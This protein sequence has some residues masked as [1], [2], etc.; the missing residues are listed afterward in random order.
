[1]KRR[2]Y[3]IFTREP[4]PGFTK[5]R[6]MPYLSP[7]ECVQLHK[8]F[9]MDY[10]EMI[11]SVDADVF[12]YCLSD[13]GRFEFVEGCFGDAAEV[14][15]QTGDSLNRKMD[16]A[17]RDVLAM[18]YESCVLTGCDIP[19]LSAE[20][21]NS[22]F[23]R[24][25]ECDAVIGPT[26][27]GGYYLIG[28]N[29]HCE[30]AFDDGLP[31]EGTVFENTLSALSSTGMRTELADMM[32]DLDTPDDIRMYRERLR[33]NGRARRSHT[34]ECVSEL[35]RISIIVPVYN[36][37]TTVEAMMRQ[38]EP[39]RDK[40]EIVFV[41][42]GSSDRTLELI[43]NRYRVI[44]SPKGRGIQMNAGAKASEGDV[45]FFLHCDS[46]IPDDIL[47]QIRAV[48]ETCSYGCFGL[49]YRMR[50]IFMWT[51]THISNFRAWHRGLPFGD[52]GIFMTRELF[53]EIGG[54]PEIP[55]M[56]DLELGMT[57]RS[58]G[59]MPGRTRDRITAS[60]RRYQGRWI[61]VLITELRMWSLR[62]RYFRGDDMSSIASAYE[63]IR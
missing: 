31:P 33:R 10:R 36:E 11:S 2:A 61:D 54:Y 22:A 19:E 37:E 52:Q 26:F 27:D 28:M 15:E 14:R 8:S 43:G 29:K 4:E 63:D 18:G 13:N 44:S 57:L 9:L 62:R 17:I 3:I 51:N 49:K 39:Y 38:L 46:V 20:V 53:D 34:A 21:I 40:A 25:G 48:M 5:T 23:V 58:K 55:V 59:I 32:Y 1:M 30:K 45:L 35:I 47:T 60:S 50:H 56:E 16:N 41:D 42:G 12:V 7:E 24:L 6:M